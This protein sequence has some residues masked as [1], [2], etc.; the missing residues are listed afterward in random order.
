MPCLMRIGEFFC[1]FFLFVTILEYSQVVK[2]P[3]CREN[4]VFE[5]E[6]GL[7]SLERFVH[8]KDDFESPRGVILLL[9]ISLNHRMVFFPRAL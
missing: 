2:C 9:E 3:E 5:E 6:N 4:T 7:D 1:L 8:T